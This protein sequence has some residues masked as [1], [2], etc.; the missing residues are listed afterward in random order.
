[1]RKSLFS[2]SLIVNDENVDT[3]FCLTNQFFSCSFLKWKDKSFE[4]K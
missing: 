4:Y 1:M 2:N 3:F